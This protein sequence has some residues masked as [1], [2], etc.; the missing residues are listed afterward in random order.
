MIIEVT[1]T[2][3]QNYLPECVA[4]NRVFSDTKELTRDRMT[5]NNNKYKWYASF[6]NGN[7]AWGFYRNYGHNYCKEKKGKKN[8]VCFVYCFNNSIIYCSFLIVTNEKSIG[9]EKYDGNDS[10]VTDFI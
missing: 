1:Y 5:H 7:G 8:Y 9:E 4:K 3:I 10:Q 2:R 6:K